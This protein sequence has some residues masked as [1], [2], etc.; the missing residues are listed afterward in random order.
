MLACRTQLPCSRT[1]YCLQRTT[2]ALVLLLVVASRSCFSYAQSPQEPCRMVITAQLVQS[3]SAQHFDS[4]H[5][6]AITMHYDLHS[7]PAAKGSSIRWTRTADEW[8]WSLYNHTQGGHLGADGPLGA[9]GPLGAFGRIQSRFHGSTP[10]EEKLSYTNNWCLHAPGRN[11]S[12]CEYGS[13]G[14]LGEQGPLSEGSYYRSMYHSGEGTTG[15]AQSFNINQDASGVFGILG[16]LGPTGPLGPLGLLGP[17]TLSL[18]PGITTDDYGVFH[19]QSDVIRST[20]PLH[21]DF[22]GT[23]FRQYD[24]FEMYSR[25]YAIKMGAVPTMPRND[26]SFGVDSFL[27]SPSPNGDLYRF[28]SVRA[29]WV[30]VTVVPADPADRFTLTV[31]SSTNEGRTYDHIVATSAN[32]NA[33]LAN[34]VVFRSNPKSDKAVEY[35]G[36]V[37]SPSP[38]HVG[39]RSGYFLYVVGSGFAEGAAPN[40]VRPVDYFS[41]RP[42][43]SGNYSFNILGSHQSCLP[44]V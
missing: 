28:D 16:P 38:G 1:L 23:V 17:L 42:Q 36:A 41:P 34:F 9:M 13:N 11:D 29:Q 26:C 12:W 10:E 14:E 30:T 39:Q 25:D 24:L 15:W 43:A 7:D 22:S 35:L 31:V 27:Q 4:N 20:A 32:T 33:S 40:K 3:L 8:G 21:F 44:F 37:V 6:G 2:A 5:G 19:Y 18:Q